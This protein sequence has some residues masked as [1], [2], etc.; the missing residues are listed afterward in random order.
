[1]TRGQ[2]ASCRVVSA[3]YYGTPQMLHGGPQFGL[4]AICA[5]ESSPTLGSLSSHVRFLT[6]HHWKEDPPPLKPATL[7]GMGEP[8]WSAF[9]GSDRVQK[10]YLAKTPASAPSSRSF[11]TLFPSTVFH[12][13]GYLIASPSIHLPFHGSGTHL[14]GLRDTRPLLVL[15][16]GTGCNRAPASTDWV[17]LD[18]SGLLWARVAR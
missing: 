4:A 2:P 15:I 3:V 11:R 5:P 9:S 1:M 10:A 18:L 17:V 14:T 12:P 8:G 7:R 16:S 13:T 6:C